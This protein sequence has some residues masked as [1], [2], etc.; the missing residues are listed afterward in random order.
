MGHSSLTQSEQERLDVTIQRVQEAREFL[1]SRAPQDDDPATWFLYLSVLK[2]IQGNADNDLSFLACILAKRYLLEVHGDVSFDAAHRLQGAPG[3]D[4]D[5]RAADGRRVIGE[6]KT[7]TP[8]PRW[9]P[10]TGH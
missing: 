7:T 9:T 4:I 10:K 3:L 6:V 8:Y 5:F 2:T 1:C